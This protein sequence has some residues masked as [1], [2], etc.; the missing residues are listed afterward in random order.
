MFKNINLNTQKYVVLHFMLHIS[1][2]K[3][4]LPCI[5]GDRYI[6]HLAYVEFNIYTSDKLPTNESF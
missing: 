3:K 6:H 4:A 5:T 2:I 1:I